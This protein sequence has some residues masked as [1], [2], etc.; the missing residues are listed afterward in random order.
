LLPLFHLVPRNSKHIKVRREPETEGKNVQA[1][2]MMHK[3]QTA[4]ALRDK[5]LKNH[6]TDM[7]NEE[8]HSPNE[9][10]ERMHP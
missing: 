3:V 6:G 7:T 4:T 10:T 9:Y 8:S 2:L 5:Q 1:S